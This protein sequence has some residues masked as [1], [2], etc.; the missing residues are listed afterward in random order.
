MDGR[1]GMLFWVGPITTLR[2]WVNGA[3]VIAWRLHGT[4]TATLR[5]NP[6]AHCQQFATMRILVIRE[7]FD[8]TQRHVDCLA[9]D[10]PASIQQ[11]SSPPQC[12]PCNP[13]SQ[14]LETQSPPVNEDST[15]LFCSARQRSSARS[16]LRDCCIRLRICAFSRLPL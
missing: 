10:P 2:K 6:R 12:E 13:Y 4:E 3:G 11:F 8:Q 7:P 1:S 14:P 9:L 16:L 15:P 5:H